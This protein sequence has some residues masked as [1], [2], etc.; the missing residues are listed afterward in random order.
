MIF[1]RK[2]LTKLIFCILLIFVSWCFILII[3]CLLSFNKILINSLYI[4]YLLLLIAQDFEIIQDSFDFPTFFK[5]WSVSFSN[6]PVFFFLLF[7][8]LLGG[9]KV[10]IV[11]FSEET[12]L[13]QLISSFERICFY[14][15]DFSFSFKF[16]STSFQLLLLAHLASIFSNYLLFSYYVS[17]FVQSSEISCSI[18][19]LLFYKSNLFIN[20]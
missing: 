4:Y 6:V 13:S 18:S 20:G 15:I 8:V 7:V 16:Q 14:L 19:D 1:R 3:D 10:S 11:L 5:S 9:V 2:Y 12:F 17:I